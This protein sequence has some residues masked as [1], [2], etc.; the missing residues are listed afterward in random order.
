MRPQL[1]LFCSTLLLVLSAQAASPPLPLLEITPAW[2]GLYRPD[3]TT[4]LKLRIKSESSGLATITTTNS[5]PIKRVSIELT[6]GIAQEITIPITFSKSH[7]VTLQIGLGNHMLSKKSVWF[8]RIALTPYVVAAAIEAALPPTVG[9]S[10][11]L[12]LSANTLPLTSQAYTMIDALVVDSP[13][14]STL[15]KPQLTAL[16]GFLKSCGQLIV[17]SPPHDI[18]TAL[19][20]SSGCRGKNIQTVDT[21][22]ALAI[23]LTSFN[24]PKTN[25][26]LDAQPLYSL[27]NETLTT[28]STQ[29]HIE[30]FFILYLAALVITTVLVRKTRPVIYLSVTAALLTPIAWSGNNPQLSAYTLLSIESGSANARIATLLRYQGNGLGETT[31]TLPPPLSDPQLMSSSLVTAPITID[32]QP[33]SS[34]RLIVKTA[35]QSQTDLYLAGSVRFDPQIVLIDDNGHAI[36][37]NHSTTPLAAGVLLWRGK[38]GRTPAIAPHERWVQLDHGDWPDKVLSPELKKLFDQYGDPYDDALFIESLPNLGGY[39]TYQD[40]PRGGMIIHAQ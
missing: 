13:A 36:I 25:S 22:E 15:S 38:I 7:A 33:D 29:R 12:P 9:E 2:Q 4:E 35:L 18:Y 14:L 16:E 11:V 3:R 28:N 31:L 21:I 20:Q 19:I 17:L 39:T 27:A 37:H 6:A 40:P 10:T 1:A 34:R 32:I 24:I 26:L 30:L 8:D 5:S 23:L